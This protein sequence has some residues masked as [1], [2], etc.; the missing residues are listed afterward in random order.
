MSHKAF[1][2]ALNQQLKPIPKLILLY[3][4][5][6]HNGTSDWCFP[7]VERIANECM[8]SESSVHK[9]LNQL[10][11]DVGLI[12]KRF[13]YVES[14]Q[15]SSEY[16][17]HFDKQAA[18]IP[19]KPYLFRDKILVRD[20]HACRYCGSSI[21]GNNFHL[22]HVYPKSRGGKRTRENTVTSCAPCNIRKHARTPKEAGMILLPV[23]DES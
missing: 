18:C 20:G 12:T 4:A 21:D 22:D 5:Y 6:A 15:T 7:S 3:L 19:S 13:R 2:W 16:I 14:R 1:G 17:L 23:G 10:E 8:I 9:Y 11:V